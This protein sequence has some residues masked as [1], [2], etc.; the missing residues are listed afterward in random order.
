MKNYQPNIYFT[1]ESISWLSLVF[2]IFE[3]S[4]NYLISETEMLY[5][6]IDP[7][8]LHTFDRF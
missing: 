2:N 8:F 3:R 1:A 5:A 7:D 6:V 4:Y